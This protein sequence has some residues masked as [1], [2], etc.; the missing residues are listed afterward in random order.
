[1]ETRKLS[2]LDESFYWG[3]TGRQST[4]LTMR[5]D[6]TQQV[7]PQVL[8]SAL[9]S[10]LQVHTNFRIR[11][12][13]E[14]GR[15]TAIVD[16]VKKAPLF[17]DDGTTKHLGTDEMDGMLLYASYGESSIT[18]HVFHGLADLHGIVAFYK[19]LL[20]FYFNALG[21]ISVELPEPDSIDTAPIYEIIL[22]KG[23]PGEPSNVFVASEHDIF[24]L[25]VE[26]FGAD[27]TRQRVLEIHVPLQPML[28]LAKESKS[29]VV[30]T[31]EAVIGHAIRKT[32]EVGEKEIVV[33]TTTDLR[34][35][36]NVPTGGN[37]AVAFSLPYTAEYD[38]YDIHERAMRLRND[39]KVQLQPANFYAAV[40]TAV[41]RL[42]PV[43]SMPVPIDMIAPR[44]VVAGREQDR[45]SYTYGISYGGKVSFG[46]QLDPFVTSIIGYTGTYSYP[47]WIVANELN[48]VI[49]LVLLQNY[50]SDALAKAIFNE[51]AEL[52]PEASY[53]D[54]GHV[55]IDELHLS[56]LR[57][58]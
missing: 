34:Q 15:I 25:P 54:T 29:S 5:V 39:M 33:Y 13:I 24:Y 40:A 12:V 56:D 22:S 49:R 57:H 20:T 53:V 55:N 43:T 1:M 28:A 58:I 16:D 47:L 46:E 37:G 21:Q 41:E 38:S 32:Y 14:N 44:A 52:I 4:V 51:L 30:P 42:K 26:T 23:A 18:L 35:V 3:R 45:K 2:F 17:K 10:A 19:T 48:G 9:T 50:E 7:D 8:E 11:P 27:T 36:F 6:L 31:L